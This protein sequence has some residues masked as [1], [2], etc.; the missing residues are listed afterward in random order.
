MTKPQ[1]TPDDFIYV[2]AKNSG[3]EGHSAPIQAFKTL[4]DALA[5]QHTT[6]FT[7]GSTDCAIYKVPVW[8]NVRTEPYY[9]IKEEINV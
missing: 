4:D 3:C 8:P 2:I 5:V 7:N 1:T 6:G 9:N